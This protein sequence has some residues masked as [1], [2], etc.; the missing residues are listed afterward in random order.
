MTREGYILVAVILAAA[1][2][3]MLLP[4]L[5]EAVGGGPALEAA[6]AALGHA[7]LD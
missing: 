7:L 1:A 2:A 4:G 3:R 5:T 6:V